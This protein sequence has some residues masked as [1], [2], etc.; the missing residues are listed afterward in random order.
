MERDEAEDFCDRRTR[1][2]GSTRVK[3]HPTAKQYSAHYN[4][5]DR[6]D[7][8]VADWGLDLGPTARWYL[9]IV[10]WLLSIAIH[11][12]FCIT[13]DMAGSNKERH[14]DWAAYT[15]EGGRYRFQ[16]DLAH[17]WRR[18]HIISYILYD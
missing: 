15:K 3:T 8:D 2:K 10:F 17:A 16:M 9:R 5:V 12:M 6:A 18:K 7:R 4:A 11:N 14:G 13:K 1:G